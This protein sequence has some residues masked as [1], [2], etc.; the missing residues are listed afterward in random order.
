MITT[1]RVEMRMMIA[2]HLILTMVTLK[3]ICL[4]SA[5][6][7]LVVPQPWRSPTRFFLSLMPSRVVVVSPAAVVFRSS[8]ADF[9]VWVRR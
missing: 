3:V 6:V 8:L 2:G 9:A 5:P 7:I 1:V 4:P